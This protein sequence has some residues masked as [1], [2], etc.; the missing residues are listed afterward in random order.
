MRTLDSFSQ[1]KRLVSSIY[2]RPAS[3]K[4][5]MHASLV[6]NQANQTTLFFL[7]HCRTLCHECFQQ[8]LF[9][10]TS[11]AGLENSKGVQK[12]IERRIERQHEDGHGYVDLA[13][14]G[15]VFGSQQTQQADG[16]PAE[17]V[18]HHHCEKAPRHCQIFTSLVTILSLSWTDYGRPCR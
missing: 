9:P 10:R 11:P 7:P 6:L 18:G 3:S 16:E 15:H 17:K 2:L 5:F 12:G 8:S 4:L 14:N 1:G 13:R